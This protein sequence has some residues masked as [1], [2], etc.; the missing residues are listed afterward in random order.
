M[1]QYYKDIFSKKRTAAS[2]LLVFMISDELR[3]RKPYAIPVRFLSLKSI[4]DEK[5]RDLELEI[6]DS[7][8]FNG[9]V[10]V[11]T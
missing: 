5:L 4:T 1:L 8:K 3:N 9:M 2:Y 11:G 7:M 6:E 10:P